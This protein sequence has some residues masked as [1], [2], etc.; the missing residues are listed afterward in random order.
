MA[1]IRLTSGTTQSGSGTS[2]LTAEQLRIVLTNYPFPISLGGGLNSTSKDTGHI[3]VLGGIGLTGN[4]YLSNVF[5]SDNITAA[6]ITLYYNLTVGTISSRIIENSGLI[7]ATSGNIGQF[8]AISV[9]ASQATVNSL[10]VINTATVENIVASAGYITTQTGSTASISTVNSTNV[11]VT[12]LAVDTIVPR[13]GSQINLGLLNQLVISGGS[14]GYALTTDGAGNLRWST[15]ALNLSVGYGLIKDG[16]VINLATSGIS[17]GTYT[18]VTVDVYGRTV[19]G[20]YQLETFGSVTGRGASTSSAIV[21]NNVRDSEDINI[22]ALVVTGGVGVGLTLTTTNLVVQNS[23]NFQNGITVQNSTMLTGTVTLTAQSSGGVPLVISSGSLNGG[24]SSGSIEYDGQALYITTTAGRQIIMLRQAGQTT[25]P[26]ILVNA[27]A[28]VNINISNPNP[29]LFDDVVLNT[30]DKVVLTAQNNAVDNGVYVFTATG[31]A[32]VRSS[33]SNI[34]TGIYSGTE[35]NVSAGTIYAGSTWRLETTGTIVVGS[36]SLTINHIL[37]KDNIAIARLNKNSSAGIITRTTYG[38]VALRSITTT[39]P[40]LSITNPTGAAGDITIVSSIVPVASGGTGRDSFFGYLRGLGTITTSSNTIPI[41]SVT[42]VGTMATQNAN[43]VAI[44]GGTVSISNLTVAGNISAGTVVSGNVYTNYYFYANGT[45]YFNT[46]LTGATGVTGLTGATGPVGPRGITGSPG[47]TGEIGSTGPQGANGTSGAS[48]VAGALGASGVAGAAGAAG[49]SGASG[50]RGAT[51]A[52]GIQGASVVLQ[53]TVLTIADLP[54]VPTNW[55]TYAGHGWIVTYGDG[56]SHLDGS[57]WFWNLAAGYWSDIGKIVGPA[58]DNG[59]SGTQG[60]L[61]ASGATGGLGYTGSIGYT[62]STG[63]QGNLGSSGATGSTGPTGLRGS[64][65]TSITIIGAVPNITYLVGPAA[66]VS[67]TFGDGF[68]LND[69]GHLAVWN[70]STFADIGNITGPSGATG[71]YGYSGSRGYTGS[72]GAS[73]GTGPT[74]PSGYGFTYRGAHDLG[75]TYNP[76]DVVT[77]NGSSYLKITYTD[78]G[79]SLTDGSHWNLIVSKGDQG[80]IGYTG[81]VGATG[82]RGAT[83]YTG[84]TGSFSATAAYQ[85]ITSNTTIATNTT[86]GALQVAGGAGIGGN[87]YVGGNVVSP[88][89]NPLHNIQVTINDVPPSSP[90]IGDVWYDSASGASYQYISDGTSA[91]WIQFGTSF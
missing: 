84:Y 37:S 3:T 1:I 25:M 62:G 72:V 43:A 55:N 16:T 29:A 67:G 60:A 50:A 24:A 85:I 69:N 66:V 73:G 87:L 21:I 83:G 47:V 57:L 70:G 28:T 63:S 59:A 89:G 41:S 82:P 5:A 38:S 8:N 2:T 81:S 39:S 71:A 44:T 17:A 27:V 51:G 40:F 11:N 6:N 30:Y 58:G 32:L 48:G 19:A 49:A 78:T 31:V 79:A 4:L 77:N 35:Y 76:Y 36:T 23:A 86:S 64:D 52:T 34:I 90:N 45:P 53:G 54:A 18:A 12:N 7:T 61:G 46:G 22:G 68:I 20:S 88:G 13:T 80:I 9:T 26:V 15:S 65:G 74:G 91:F 56:G 42:G 33:D 75:T 10:T 14:D